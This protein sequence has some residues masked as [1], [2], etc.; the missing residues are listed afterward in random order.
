VTFTSNQAKSSFSGNPCTLSPVSGASASCSVTFSIA[1][2]TAVLTADYNGD[3]D[4]THSVSSGQT[5]VRVAPRLTSTA[6]DCQQTQLA[7]NEQTTC[8]VTVTD[9]SSGTPITPTGNVKLAGIKTDSFSPASC[10]LSGSGA[11]A[12]CSVSYEPTAGAPG[13]SHQITAHYPGQRLLAAS[14]GT[15]TITIASADH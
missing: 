1:T 2:A 13:S 6:L 5:T 10:T 4:G 7:V 15:T 8:L 3:G 11:S 12:S 9:T 14:T